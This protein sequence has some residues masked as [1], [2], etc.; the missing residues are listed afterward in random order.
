MRQALKRL[1]INSRHPLLLIYY[2]SHL[3][4]P[5]HLSSQRLALRAYSNYQRHVRESLSMMKSPILWTLLCASIPV[6][7]Y[8]P[9]AAQSPAT[10]IEIRQ[11]ISRYAFASDEKDLDALS[12]VFTPDAV[13][14]F[15][16]PPP[17]DIIRGLPAI[18]AAL[19][20]QLADYV[21]QHTMSTT[22]VDNVNSRSPN[23]TAYL[24]A[25]YLGQGNLTGQLLSFYGKYLDQWEYQGRQWKIK[26]RELVLFVSIIVLPVSD[27]VS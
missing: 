10:N 16:L 24:V 8:D 13:V 4:F 14:K 26:N 20:I 27:R 21:T 5:L 7:A 3:F 6:L 22:V 15:P 11:T 18:K 23:S 2:A 12:K 9:R 17:N 25:N 1:A 19:K